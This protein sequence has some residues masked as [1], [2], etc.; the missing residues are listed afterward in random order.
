M[1][2]VK[3]AERSGGITRSVIKVMQ[4]TVKVGLEEGMSGVF[5]LTSL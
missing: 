2:I 1:E 5:H 4:A 3:K